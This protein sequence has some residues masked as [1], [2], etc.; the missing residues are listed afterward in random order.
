MFI[1]DKNEYERLR[2][3]ASETASDNS[4]I[5]GSRKNPKRI[6]EEPQPPQYSSYSNNNET[7]YKAE[8]D[9]PRF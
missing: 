9:D 7:Y 4:R 2:Q 1:N 5:L 3:K 6:K 8:E